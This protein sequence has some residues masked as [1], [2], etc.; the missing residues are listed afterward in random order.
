MT[1]GRLILVAGA[2]LAAGILASLVAARVRVPALVLF[3]ALGMVIGSDGTGWID[4]NDYELARTFGVVA[5][6]LILFE[7]GLTSGLLE[8]RPVLG[9]AVSLATVGTLGTAVISG[10]AASWLFGFSTLEGLLLG[11]IVAATD[12]AAVFSLLRGS[13]LRRKLARTLEGESGLND[14]VAVLLVLG[15]IAWI[16]Q[17]DY[18][19]GDMAVLFARELLAGLAVGGVVGWLSVLVLRRSRLATAGLYPVA[20]LAAAAIAYGGADTLHGSGFL[21]VY[22]TGLVL[23]TATIP[24]R[25]TVTIFHEG[26]GWVAQ[27]SMFLVLG[28]LVFPAQLDDVAL[29]GTLLALI[30]AFVARPVA[31]FV[32]TA[33]AAYTAAERVMLGWAGLRGAIPVVLATFPVIAEV[34]GSLEF[35]NLVFFAVVLSTLLQGATFE[36]LA[37]RLGVTTS[38]PA[39]PRPLAEAGGARRLGAEVVE[40]PIHEDDAVV[41]SPVRDLGLPREAMVSLIVREEQAIPPRGSTRLRAGDR[42]HVLVG[43]EA[44]RDVPD[45][46]ERWHA[47][48]VGPPPRPA[49]RGHGRPP[50]FIARPWHE[51]EGNPAQPGLVEGELVVERLRI[52]RDVPGALVALADGRYAITGPV[53]A[54]GGRTE[55]TRWARRRMRLAGPDEQAWLQNVVGALAADAYD[56]RTDRGAESAP[57]GRPPPAR[58][59][60]PYSSDRPSASEEGGEAMADVAI[61]ASGPREF[62]VEVRQDGEETSHRVTVPEDLI[63]ELDLAEGDLERVVRESFDFL[64]EREPPSSILGEFSL[65]EISRYFPEYREELSRRLS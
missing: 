34:P 2:L 57:A 61:T 20:T 46:L 52:R 15:F 62:R 14:P 12:S 45:V 47:G 9:P 63:D 43:D 65:D 22:L 19:L 8:I 4:F 10:L 53:V 51:D 59:A 37:R 17:P 50:V 18:G 56:P 60:S 38:E 54:A 5:L 30:V 32:A 28:L 13:T 55:L 1:E 11:S 6:A 39:L 7:G 31:A 49:R 64:L 42:L 41:G 58:R 25:Q 26:V 36:P 44:A 29:E 27:I 16:E 33:P 35:F 3:L 40:Y 48:P 23:G 21:A 24:A